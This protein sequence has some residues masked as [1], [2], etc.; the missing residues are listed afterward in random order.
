M[1]SCFYNFIWNITTSVDSIKI[2]SSVQN[3]LQFSLNAFNG[4]L[5]NKIP[6]TDYLDIPSKNRR[7]YA[8]H[9]DGKG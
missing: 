4:E 5:E 7:C 6:H 9:F 8:N 3:V 1:L 2:L